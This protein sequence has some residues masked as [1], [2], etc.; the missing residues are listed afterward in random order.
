MATSITLVG[1]GLDI[2]LPE[3]YKGSFKGF[4][5]DKLVVGVRPEH[6]DVNT[7]GPAGTLRAT[8]TSSSTSATRSS[9]T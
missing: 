6:L 9:S 4:S 7:E 2:P 5:G 1:D 3:R 8:R